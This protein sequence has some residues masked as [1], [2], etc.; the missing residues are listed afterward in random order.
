MSPEEQMLFRA[1]DPPDSNAGVRG[2][3]GNIVGRS[4]RVV[5]SIGLLSK[6]VDAAMDVR[7]VSQQMRGERV[8]HHLRL[9]R[10]R[11]RVEGDERAMPRSSGEDREVGLDAE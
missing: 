1:S 6:R 5:G 11:P 2:N 8:D 7:V 10:G 4:N 9:L 3:P